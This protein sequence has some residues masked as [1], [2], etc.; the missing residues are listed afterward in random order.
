MCFK[1]VVYYKSRKRELKASWIFNVTGLRTT[2]PAPG[3]D[4]RN[5]PI[6]YIE[7]KE[8]FGFSFIRIICQ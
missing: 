3:T 7:E 5:I 2:P 6:A 8:C 4:F 1:C